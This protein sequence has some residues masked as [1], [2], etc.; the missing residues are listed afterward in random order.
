MGQDKVILHVLPGELLV[1]AVLA[2]G[3]IPPPL[4][5]A[6]AAPTEWEG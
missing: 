2:T 3:C 4:L 1:D 6:R 5:L